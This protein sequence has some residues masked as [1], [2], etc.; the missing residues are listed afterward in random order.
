MGEQKIRVLIV[1]DSALIRNVMTEI[2]SQDTGIEVVGTAP[3]PYVARDKM[4]A[5]NPDVLTLDV[6]MPKMDGLT[7]LQKIMSARPMPVVMVSSLTEQGAATTLKALEAGAVDFVT[8]PTVD[9]QHGLSDLAHQIV[10]KVKIAAQ[11]NV[12]KRTLP[13][14]CAER[15]KALAAQSAMIKTTDTIIAI[16]ASTGGTEAL[17]ELLEVLPPNTPPII[18]TQHMPERFTKSFANRLNEL[19]QIHVKEAQE[20]D[21]VIPGQALL[22]PGNY[23]MELRRSG[24]RYYVSLNQEPLVN[25][26][27]PSVDVMFRSVARYAGGNSVGVILTG[28]GNDGAAGMLEM[29]QAGA[30]NFAQDEASCVVFGMPKEAIKAGGVDKILPLNDIPA[31]MLAHLKM[32][33]SR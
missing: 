18:L 14:D 28:M 9:I 6:E 3:D 4:K 13:D 2:L 27:R 31:A 29:K 30:V 21:S 1:D 24:A 17:R 8:K 22:A 11:A 19:C 20:G 32:M 12:K 25:R 33:A 10:N 23:H 16:G 15:I 7:F 26:F 5:L